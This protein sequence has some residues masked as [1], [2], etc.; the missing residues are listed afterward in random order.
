[1]TVYAADTAASRQLA[2]FRA[3]GWRLLLSPGKKPREGFGYALDNGAW[4]A[5][6]RGLPFDEAAF[7]AHLDHASGADWCVL[8]DKVGLGHDSLAYSLGWCDRVSCPQLLAVQDGV[9]PDDIASIM[10]TPII[11]VFLGGTTHW[12][13][14]WMSRWGA[15][16]RSRSLLFHVGRVNTRRRLQ[17][18][19]QAGATS[20]DG[21][22]VSRFAIHAGKV[23]EWIPAIKSQLFLAV[24]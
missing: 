23:A 19:W 22:G 18:A 10:V 7:T 6:V 20:I 2:I 21:S 1:M 9:T 3:H 16:C 11:G 15:F 12:K 13:E 5:H 4:G 8:P 17:W 14:Q 24:G